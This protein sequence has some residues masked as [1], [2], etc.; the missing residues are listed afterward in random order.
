MVKAFKLMQRCA[1]LTMADTRD[2]HIYDHLLVEP[3]ANKGWQVEMIAWDTATD[4]DQFDVVVTRSP[5]DYM[6]RLEEFLTVLETI[7]ASS[8][9]LEN[10]LAMMRWN[11]DKRYLSKLAENGCLIVPTQFKTTLT[12]EDIIDSFEHFNTDQIVIKP[13]VSASA[14]NTFRVMRS[15]LSTYQDAILATFESRCAMLQPFIDAVTEEG[16]YSLFYF[17]NQLSHAILKTPKPG[18]FRVQEEYGGNLKLITP[19]PEL[20]AAGNDALASIEERLLYARVDLVRLA[21][22]RF[23]LMELEL[24]EPSLYFNLDNASPERFAQEFVKY[25]QIS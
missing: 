20:L 22:N 9:R 11:I 23:A 25:L 7:E 8:A 19:S 2:Y 5:W 18:D 16:E 12:R 24:I 4:W 14:L 6:D 15:N 1:F 3:L 21:D 13:T 10:P 17:N